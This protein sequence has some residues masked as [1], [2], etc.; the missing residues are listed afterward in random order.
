MD[1][2][3]ISSKNKASFWSFKLSAHAMTLIPAAV[4]INYVAKAF[5]EGL[6]L[7]VWLGS[8]GTFLA[9]MLAG[10]IA[11]AISGFINNVIYGLTLSPV[12]SVYALTSI[13]IGLAVAWLNQRG[14]FKRPVTVLPAAILIALV[15]ALIST[16]LNVIF[17]SG[18]TGIAWGDAFFASLVAKHVN[19]WIA[20]FLDEFVLDLLDKTVVAYLAFL[21][22]KQLPQRLV[23][24]FKGTEE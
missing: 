2:K 23:Y 5:A 19:I 10:P 15:S 11:G 22:Y 20:S 3:E 18:Q 24:F 12:S 16:P 17:W 1:S 13:G 14:F 21:I 4:G 7:P 8:L 9:S 6:K